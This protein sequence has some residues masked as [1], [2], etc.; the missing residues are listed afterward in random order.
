[1]AS[2][3]S[4]AAEGLQSGFNMGMQYDQAQEAKRSRALSEARQAEE[5]GM[6]KTQFDAQMERQRQQDERQQTVDEY[7]QLKDAH[8]DV[9]GRVAALQGAGQQVPPELT[10]E[11]STIRDR[12]NSHRAKVL[13]PKLATERQQALD[14]FSG[15]KAGRV[16]P[17]GADVPPAQF[18]RHVAL[19][20]GRT[21]EEITQ[22]AS[23]VQQIQEGHASGNE[24]LT[25]QGVNALA[26]PD[27]RAGVGQPSPHGGT[28]V[29]KEIVKLVPA[30]DANGNTDPNQVYPVIRVYTDRKGPDGAPLYY[31]APL[32]KNRTSDPDDPV[33]PVDLTRAFEYMGN[34]GTLAAALQDPRAQAKLAQGA[35]EVGDKTR[36]DLDEMNALGR[37]ELSKHAQ[38]ALQQKIQ[39]IKAQG[40]PPEDEARAIRVAMGTEAPPKPPSGGVQSFEARVQAIKDLGLS[41]EA[42][43]AAIKDLTLRGGGKISGDVPVKAAAGK[44]TGPAGGGGGTASKPSGKYDKNPEY[45]ERVDFWAKLLANG[46]DLP[47]GFAR[48]NKEMYADVLA[49]S[50]KFAVGGATGAMADRAAYAG[51]KAG[52]RAV[53]TRAANFGLAK[54]EAYEMADLVTASSAA[55]PRTNFMPANKALNAF[56]TN[57]GNIEVR[58]FGAALNSF[59][60]AYARA[61]SPIG[62]PTVSDKNH[63]REM[64]STADSHAQVVGI[65]AQLK[66]EMDAAG[67]APKVV[68]KEL[69]TA[70]RGLGGA[71]GGA[72]PKALSPQDQAAVDWAKSNPRDPRAAQIL[73][74]HGM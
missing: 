60:N 7:Q 68:R 50:P 63:A 16:D 39:A 65:I 21:P 51:M 59:I 20:T 11:Y 71:G 14:F 28:V 41:P 62:T 3:G 46:G 17:L 8:T 6:R 74:L 27:L 10:Q 67:N 15:V 36:A 29:R 73:Q 35:K 44:G 72:A 43:K 70:V 53:E 58:Q 52:S 69:N 24:A 18:Y 26:A 22:A 61:V 42:E 2:I 13:A 37:V 19:A 25:L 33:Q 5:L 47:A 57:T 23:A 31:D 40:L 64:L 48:A 12:L 55:V 54:S 49:Q 9:I 30:Q 45:A 56:N 4:A 38:G 1:M 34:L 66:K 32:T